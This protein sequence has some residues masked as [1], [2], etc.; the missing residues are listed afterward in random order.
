MMNT[1]K[2]FV[3]LYKN[4]TKYQKFI[5]I[6]IFQYQYKQK[7]KHKIFGQKGLKEASTSL[8]LKSTENVDDTI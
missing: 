6:L 4:C 3:K 8:P 7:L 2:S 5:V 1:I